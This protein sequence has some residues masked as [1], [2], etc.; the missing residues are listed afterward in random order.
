LEH[1][2]EVG[3][4]IADASTGNGASAQHWQRPR[5]LP[6]R[7]LSAA[8][9]RAIPALRYV[10][11]TVHPRWAIAPEAIKRL[12]GIAVMMLSLRLLLTP[13]PLSIV[14]PALVIALISLAYLEEDWLMLS[15]GLLAGF[16]V[17]AVDLAVLWEAVLGAKRISRFW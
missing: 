5:T 4:G 12:V 3:Q 16:A 10:E 7:R 17:L 9:Q 2:V 11:K 15:I 13:I 14:I 6:T 1:P 8:L